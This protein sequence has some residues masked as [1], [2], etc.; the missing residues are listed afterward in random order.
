M[1]QRGGDPKNPACFHNLRAKPDTTVRVGS[2]RT[3]VRAGVADAKE[4]KRL[5]PEVVKAYRGYESYRRH[6]ER[7]IP[8]VILAPR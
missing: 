2:R 5:W 7:E 3:K 4:R 8:L 6:T 1:R